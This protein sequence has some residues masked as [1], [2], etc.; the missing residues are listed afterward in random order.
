MDL[1]RGVSVLPRLVPFGRRAS[2]SLHRLTN[3]SRGPTILNMQQVKKVLLLLALAVWL[4][5]AD[6]APAIAEPLPVDPELVTGE[7][8]N[9]LRYVIKKHQNPAGRVSLWL[10]VASGSLNETDETRGIA[11][12]LEHMAFNG[13]ANFPPGALVPFF[14]S[15][16][17]AFGR[18]QNAFTGFG[19]TTYQIALPDTKPE[20]LDK[21]M[22]FLSDVAL[23]LT[24]TPAEIDN[25]RQIILEEKRSRAGPAQRVQEYIYERLAPESTFGRRLPIGTEETIKS[26]TAKE[27]KEY[28]SRWYAPGNMTV[29]VVGD[30]DPALVVRLIQNQFAEGRKVPRP[31]DREVGVKPQTTTRAIVATDPELTE[32]ELSI[33][34]VEPPRSPTTTVEQYRR[35]VVELMGVRALNRR[36]TVQLSEGKASFLA[37]G[38]SVSE[39]GGAVRFVTGEASG[40]PGEWRRMLTDLGTDIQRARLYGF[41]E[42]EL[43]DVRTSLLA[44]AEEAVR[45][46][47]TLPARSILRRI[48]G[49]LARR[50][51][52]V[53]SAQRL[54]LLKRL[55][56][57]ITVGEVSQLF[58]S[59]FDPTNVTFIAELPSGSDVPG[60]AELIELGRAALSVKPDRE[61]EVARASSLLEK[62]PTGGKFVESIEHTASG[63]TSGWLD[64]GI[65][66]HYRFMDQRKNEASIAITLAGGR[67]Q[68]TGANRGITD[69]SSLAWNRP[70]TSKLSSVQI[71]DLMIGKKVRVNGWAGQDTLTLA[72]S[73]DP[74]DL[75]TGLQLAYLLLTD[76]LIEPAVFEQWKETE[77]QNIAARK[78]KPAGVLTEAVAAAFY[79]SDEF[80]PK[81][82]ETDQVQRVGLDAAQGWLRKIIAEAPIEVTVVGDVDKPTAEKL[83]ERYLGSLPARQRINDRT[84]AA[85]RKI[86][87]P[88]GPIN[89]ERRIK[90]R[91]EQAFVMDGFFGADIQNVRDSRLL[92]MAGRVLS[93]RMNTV[94]REEKQLV[95]SIGASSQPASEYPGFGLFVAQAPTDPAKAGALATALHEMYAAFARSGPTSDEL[96]VA[97]KQIANLLD[98]TM[99]E[100][101]FWSS[102][103][104]TLDYRGLTLDHLV[105]APGDYQRFTA[106]E[107]RECFA[108]YDRPD[109]HFRFVIS[110]ADPTG[111]KAGAEHTKG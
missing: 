97:K 67:I 22:L 23:R 78:V 55:L 29:I 37:A 77:K 44:E 47:Q 38:V 30:C 18:D 20:T 31:A 32:A 64:N 11:H 110:P 103:L 45:R 16:G 15:L 56:P 106:E 107:V 9:G 2:S 65:R 7:L 73:G 40:K 48:N 35:D 75:E 74:A 72:V 33:M 111:D 8:D 58:A 60:E 66:V 68:E 62:L 57:G 96:G 101:E 109:S 14:Q 42:R 34:R 10:H 89:V 12:Y 27:L 91:T 46:E 54:E 82:L 39:Q 5:R 63:V 6:S 108:R 80:R 51:P 88:G 98:E 61:A 43:Q 4:V 99:K 53:S 85:L 17:M 25:E 90:V 50:E 28:Y 52:V 70:A 3:G 81:P 93:T 86:T 83:V 105:N 79:P 69:A 104:S 100:P 92:V 94:I 87:R 26:I 59:N 95:Y 102:R 41:S 21:G 84:L 71:R 19:Q 76:P 13:S 24:L 49:A 36:I 1:L